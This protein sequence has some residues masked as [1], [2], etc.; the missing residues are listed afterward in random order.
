MELDFGGTNPAL[1]NLVPV[2]DS[3]ALL[4]DCF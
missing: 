4:L 3:I 1:Y 2:L